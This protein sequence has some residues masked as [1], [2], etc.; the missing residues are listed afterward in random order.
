MRSILVEQSLELQRV[1][2][3]ARLSKRLQFGKTSEKL[4]SDELAQ[5][6]L[7]FDGPLDAEGNVPEPPPVPVPDASEAE[8]DEDAAAA[9]GLSDA[10]ADDSPAVPQ[11]PDVTVPERPKRHGGGG[12]RPLAEHLRKI[13]TPV[14]V[15]DAERP[16][17]LCGLERT[18]VGHRQNVRLE[19]VPGHVEAHIEKR[20]VLACI[21][22]RK[23]MSTAPR[24]ERK[25]KV[26]AAPSLLAEFLILKCDDALPLHR[27]REQLIRLGLDLPKSTLGR[28]W[29]YVT[30]LLGPLADVIVGR[31]LA[32][33]YIG[34][35]DTGLLYLKPTDKG[36]QRPGAKGHL[37]CFVGQGPLVGFRFTKTWHAQEVAEHL[38]LADGFVQGDGYGGYASEV[39]VDEETR[40]L[41]AD[42]MRLGCLVHARRPFHELVA[43]KDVR[44]NPALLL[45]QSIYK[46][47]ADYRERGLDHGQRGRERIARSLPLFDKLAQWIHGV[48]PRLRPKDPLGKATAYFINQEPYLR[49]CFM[50]GRFELDNS[51][52][53]RAIREVAIGRKNFVLTG[54]PEAAERLA[55]AYTVIESARRA[56]GTER[57][58][59]YLIDVITKLEN[60][61]PL[62]ELRTL[63]P[64]A[65]TNQQAAQHAPSHLAAD[66]T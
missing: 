31:I 11:T 49:R 57:L 37:W 32:Q 58:R 19:Y 22:C 33:Q 23:D 38:V 3:H 55:T 44:A 26:R 51:R 24:V 39:D 10:A 52:V 48:H 13:E 6:Y 36:K 29:D 1:K 59:P 21:P 40:P 65:W 53:E 41:L 15:P 28:W 45:F 34:V 46:L 56:L 17:A 50:D 43:A 62:A 12:R 20:E 54:S 4:D 35:D 5:A 63:A 30:A 27:V 14:R 25:R 47:E 7:D 60:R 42:D 16:C 2:M 66:A 9:L 8:V 18:C 64:D 61:F